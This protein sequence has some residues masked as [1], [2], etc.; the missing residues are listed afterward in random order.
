MTPDEAAHEIET[1]LRAANAWPTMKL[2]QDLVRAQ[3]IDTITRYGKRRYD[4]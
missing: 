2:E 3:I 1:A 4:K